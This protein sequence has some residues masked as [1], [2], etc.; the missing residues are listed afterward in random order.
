MKVI[1]FIGILL[2]VLLVIFMIKGALI[3]AAIFFVV[4]RYIVYAAVI[5][6]AIYLYMQATKKEL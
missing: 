3:G 6:F 5:A 4:L 1:K 2:A